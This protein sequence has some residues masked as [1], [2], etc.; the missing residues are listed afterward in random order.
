M[1]NEQRT[2]ESIGRDLDNLNHL[3]LG[4][5]LLEELVPGGRRGLGRSGC[6][7][8][9]R[10]RGRWRRDGSHAERGRWRLLAGG[11]RGRGCAQER[12]CTRRFGA[13]AADEL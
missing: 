4:Q 1:R 7:R 5:R 12:E 8:V 2:I 11:A 6:I 3:G 10:R 13:G 9:R